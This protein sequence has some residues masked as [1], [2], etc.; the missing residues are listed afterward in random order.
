MEVSRKG[1]YIQ[2]APNR[3]PDIDMR[4]C[5]RKD[6]VSGAYLCA[7]TLPNWSSFG[8]VF[9]LRSQEV[10]RAAEG[11]VRTDLGEIVTIN[12]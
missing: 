1:K 7:Y 3:G 12:I 11:S 5:N 9:V 2:L 8:T 4:T 10:P 6:N